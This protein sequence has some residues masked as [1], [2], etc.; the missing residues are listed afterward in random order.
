MIPKKASPAEEEA[1]G[2]G[3]GE[4]GYFVA[5]FDPGSVLLIDGEPRSE[6]FEVLF[7]TQGTGSYEIDLFDHQFESPVVFALAPGQ[8]RKLDLSGPSKGWLVRFHSSVF[9][10]EKE[11]FDFVIDTCLFDAA[12]MCPIIN[13]P[14]EFA[15]ILDDLFARMLEE[16]ENGEQDS[17]I[18]ISSYLRILVTHINRLKREKLAE[19]IPL[20]DP[21]YVLFR[22][23]RIELEKRFREEHSPSAFARTLGTDP[24]TLNA[25]SKRFAGSSAGR[26]IRDRLVLEAR[27]SLLNDPVSVKELSYDLGFDDPAYFTR[28]FKKHTGEAPLHFRERLSG[29][30]SG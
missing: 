1:Q 5:R 20:N 24:K 13:V 3:E 4:E 9:S 21:S 7:I 2:F 28:F 22:N 11:F 12:S 23:F 25:V 6:S 30:S 19:T 17:G 8:I 14:R 27:R 26:L 15:S 16:Q 10:Y 18:V 29:T